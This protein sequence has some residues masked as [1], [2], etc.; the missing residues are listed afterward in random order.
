MRNI[1]PTMKS[2]ASVN[3]NEVYGKVILP[4]LPSRYAGQTRIRNRY[5]KDSVRG[6]KKRTLLQSGKRYIE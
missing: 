4:Q 3:G 2:N 5:G 1:Q 6:D